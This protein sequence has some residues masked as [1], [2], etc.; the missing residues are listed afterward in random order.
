MNDL[1]SARLYTDFGGLAQLRAKA[2]SST[3]EDDTT[4]NENKLQAATEVA[5][6]F[7]AMFLQ[8]MLQTMREASTMSETTDSDQTRFYQEMFDKQI[9]IDLATR[10]RG[11]GIA[12]SLK[13]D[14][15]PLMLG[16]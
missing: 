4:N 8:T 5:Q 14:L 2:S 10:G 6:Q 9:A 13:R 1:A 16:S 12:E 15:V 3:A 7:E 11:I